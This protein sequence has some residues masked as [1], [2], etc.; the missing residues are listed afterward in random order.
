M[1]KATEI[2]EAIMFAAINDL[3]LSLLEQ[4]LCFHAATAIGTHFQN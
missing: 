1:A 3:L 2:N 4:S